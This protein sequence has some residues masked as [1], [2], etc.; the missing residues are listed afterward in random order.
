MRGAQANRDMAVNLKHYN[1]Y[2]QETNRRRGENTQN[3]VADERTIRELY[4]RPWASAV[5]E[6]LA[7]VM[8]AY[9][10]VNGEHACEH[11]YMQEQVLRRGL[12]FDGFILSDFGA[13][14]GHTVDSVEDGMDLET[15]SI[16]TY[17]PKLLAAVRDGRVS[18]ALI[19]QRVSN[20]LRVYFKFGLFDHPLPSTQQPVPAQEHGG[21]AR[22]IEQQAITLLK[23]RNAALPFQRPNRPRSIAVLGEGATW[24]A[25]QC[26]AGAVT[27]PT[28]TITP[29][30]GIRRRAPQGVDVELPAGADAPAPAD[31]TQGPDAVPSSVLSPPGAP[32][33]TGVRSEFWSNTAFSGAPFATRTD[34]RPMFDTGP[35]QFFAIHP[36]VQQLPA[37][38]RAARYS[39]T[40]TAPT[41]GSYRLSL[42]GF[43]TG[44]LVFEG[45][46]IVS[47]ANQVA[48][49]AYVSDPLEL[50]AGQSYSFQIE[51]AATNPGD[52]LDPGSVR[53]GWVP[54][55]GTVSPDVQ[56]AVDLA[57]RSDVAVVVAGLYEAEA[58][59]RGELDLPT[60]QDELIDAVSRVN[61][62][63]IV[64]LQ[65]GGPVTMPWINQVDGILQLYYGGGEQGRALADVL[66]GDV[67]P[68]GKLPIS[69]PRFDSQ[70]DALG[71]QNPL[72][73]SE[74]F[75]VPFS[76]GVFMGYRGYERQGTR[77]QFPFGYGLSYT[78]FR[79]GRPTRRPATVR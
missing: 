68:S 48:P 37:G 41:T 79:Y 3:S 22:E 31:L 59:D 49:R 72:L 28:Y 53:L 62:R 75:D 47:F 56:A 50:Q 25:Q 23:N 34:L 39:G 54:P 65:S 77:M 6:G 66:F 55:E 43:G 74:T 71:I 11:G 73:N 10:R 13:T 46:E 33:Q 52:S 69:Y 63:T 44:R 17:G 40:I 42:S 16:I 2:T 32:G 30:E 51:Y 26:C 15:G 20:I 27:S 5:G 7:S 29:L 19:N 76:E 38:S 67:N 61:P 8:C 60:E 70:P 64:V 45:R 12:G 57:E 58:R 24:A 21:M 9:N 78:R 36:E 1:L 18:E 35:I 4:S 14:Y